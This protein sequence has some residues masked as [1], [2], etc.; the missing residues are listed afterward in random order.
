MS[1]TLSVYKSIMTA[2]ALNSDWLCLSHQLQPGIP[3]FPGDPE[4]TVTAHSTVST[5]GYAVHSITLGSQSG[6]HVDTPAHFFENGTALREFPLKRFTTRAIVLDLRT[7]A[8]PAELIPSDVFEQLPLATAEADSVLVCTGWDKHWGSPTYFQNPYFDGTASTTLLQLGY[9]TFGC[10]LPSPDACTDTQL[11]FHETY[12]A[13]PDSLIIENLTGL[14]QLPQGEV[15]DFIFL[16]AQHGSPD[17]SPVN[18]IA[19]PL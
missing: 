15:I 10:D 5:A 13:S 11:P 4:V 16:P 8:Q 6:T 2:R 18:V 14:T 19:R 3:T 7:V 12:L 9:R 1:H 17:G